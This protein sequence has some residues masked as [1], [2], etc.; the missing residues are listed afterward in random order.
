MNTG[1]TKPLIIQDN[2]DETFTVM[3]EFSYDVG[4]L[5]SN[6]TI[7]VPK[8]KIT[9]FASIPKILTPIFPRYGQHTKAAVLHDYLYDLVRKEGFPRRLADFFFL[10]AM[11]ILNV[12]LWRRL[13]MYYCVRLFGWAAV[14]KKV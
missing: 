3:E 1:F 10:D 4:Y 6:L 13:I 12:P 14:R 2:G 5:G 9:D 8:G 11:K 7:I